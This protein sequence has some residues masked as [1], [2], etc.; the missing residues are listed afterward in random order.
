MNVGHLSPG[1]PHGGRRRTT[2]LLALV[3][4]ALLGAPRPAQAHAA[5]VSSDPPPG[6]RLSATPG[7]VVLRFSEPLIRD[8]SRATVV[9]PNGQRFA[10]E[11]AKDRTL[12]VRVRTNAPGVYDVEWRTVSPLDGHTLRG[13]FRFGVGTD[14]GPGAEGGPSTAPE[15]GDLLTGVARAFE[16]AALL[17]AVGMLLVGRLA[18]RSPPLG[19]VR[20]R[21]STLLLAALAAGIV[22]VGSETLRAAGGFAGTSDFLE[23]RQGLIRVGRLL[24]VAAAS[25]AAWRKREAAA[26]AALAAGFVGLAGAGH[27]AASEPSWFAIAADAGHLAAGG[28][29]AGGVL[30][31]ATLRPPGG[32]RGPEGRAL[33]DR[34]TPVALPAFVATVA[35]GVA[36]G[37][38]ELSALGD[39]VSTAY[40]QVLGLKVLVVAGM[41]PLSVLAWR[42]LGARPRSEAA[43]ALAVAVAAGALAAF[44]LP[45]QRAAEAEGE[46]EATE[47]SAALPR[48]GDLTMGGGAGDVLVGLTL[49]PGEPGANRVLVHL[50]PVEGEE[51]AEALSVRLAVDGE[52][53]AVSR[54]GTACRDAD[55]QVDGGEE[56][57]VVVSGPGGGG[58]TFVLPE[59]PAPEA[60]ELVATATRR[61]NALGTY[62]IDEVLGPTDPPLR[63][64]YT[65]IAPD[66]LRFALDTGMTTV[67]IGTTRYT[68]PSAQAPWEVTLGGPPVEVP[69]VIWDYPNPIAP[70]VVG[71]ETIRSEEVTMVSFFIELNRSPIWYRLWV[72]EG[73]LV[74]RAEMRAQGHFMDHDYSAFDEPLEVEPPSV[75]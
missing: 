12:R 26:A 52:P 1:Q 55:A 60:T 56:V 67:R 7:V 8:L 40:G 41:V 13:G 62:R 21:P 73:G 72:A 28:L 32:W 16:Y 65:L 6:A 59:L 9:D 61:M 10:S 74:L 33:L 30:A 64:D 42:R 22:V 47:P 63:A 75:G 35:L 31:L 57:D 69:V 34:F 54:C 53:L 46:E 70:R 68:R 43:L 11:P 39:L 36:R 29:W 58:T 38:Q 66:R 17:A 48:P 25:A 20:A 2:F 44:P 14:P 18:R 37:F 5:F 4:L 49:R 45:P 71:R 23:N 51:T 15:S 19:W 3:G 24:A 27:A 50:L